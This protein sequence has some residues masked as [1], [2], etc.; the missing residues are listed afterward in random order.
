MVN[1]TEKQEK[2]GF[3]KA[4]FYEPLETTVVRFKAGDLLFGW[5]KVVQTLEI[6]TR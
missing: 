3:C 5:K 2:V 1:E 4:F 6:V